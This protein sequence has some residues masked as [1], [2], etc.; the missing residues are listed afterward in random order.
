MRARLN[1]PVEKLVEAGMRR[2]YYATEGN[3]GGV[4][5]D[6]RAGRLINIEWGAYVVL[7]SVLTTACTQARMRGALI[8]ET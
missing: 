8:S 3:L 7:K 5:L 2:L 4:A 1:R 6:F